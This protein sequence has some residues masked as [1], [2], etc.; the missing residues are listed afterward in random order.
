MELARVLRAAPE[1]PGDGHRVEGYL[2]SSARATVP[3]PHALTWVC[4]SIHLHPRQWLIPAA[5][6]V[7]TRGAGE[8]E[9]GIQL[10]SIFAGPLSFIMLSCTPVTATTDG[11]VAWEACETS[12]WGH[13][14]GVQREQPQKA[15]ERSPSRVG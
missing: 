4:R 15:M 1:G 10:G 5:E 14:E 7:E 12:R 6:A 11:M 8:V 3:R 2:S 9:G 13:Q